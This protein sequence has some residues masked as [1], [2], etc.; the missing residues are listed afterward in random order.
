MKKM[1][2]QPPPLFGWIELPPF[3]VEVLEV[4]FEKDTAL[5]R[6]AFEGTLFGAVTGATEV[7]TQTVRRKNL[8]HIQDTT[9]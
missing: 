5:V 4:D 9:A 8:S 2:Y 1:N 3:E 6:H 7:V